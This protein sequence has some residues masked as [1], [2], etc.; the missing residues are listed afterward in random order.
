MLL[1]FR[2]PPFLFLRSENFGFAERNFQ[3]RLPW[4]YTIAHGIISILH[5]IILHLRPYVF[6]YAL[7]LP[8]QLL[9]F[10]FSQL[11]YYFFCRQSLFFFSN[12]HFTITQS[13]P[14][15][16]I[17]FSHKK[18]INSLYS[19]ILIPIIILYNLEILIN[20]AIIYE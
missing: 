17:A 11:L 18:K 19:I 6:C 2:V 16:S 14:I 1:M 4:I 9:I 3:F 10:I 13:V 15:S 20:K 7:H 8:L 5:F 12:Y